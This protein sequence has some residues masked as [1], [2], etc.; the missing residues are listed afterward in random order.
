MNK[1]KKF[2]CIVASMMTCLL[3]FPMPIHAQE[4]IVIKSVDDFSDFAKKA[5]LDTWSKDKKIILENDLDFSNTDFISIPYFAGTFD[6][7]G[8]TLSGIRLLAS[9]PNQ[10][11]FR[12]LDEAGTIQ[13]LKVDVTIIGK[14]DIH[15]IG[16]IVGENRG[17]ILDCFAQVEM[18]GDAILGGIAGIN[19]TS[20][21]IIHC[22]TQGIITSLQY[23]G[24]IVGKNYGTISDCTNQSKI[25]PSSQE[26]TINL[27]EID[28]NHITNLTED[29]HP[30]SGHSDTGGIA[31]YS[32]GII[33][34]CLN[35]ANLG[36]PHIGYN[37]GGIV[38]RQAGYLSN[39]KNTGTIYGRKDVGGIVGQMEPSMVLAY[40][41]DSLVKLRNDLNQL[42]A[43]ID[44]ALDHNDVNIADLSQQIEGLANAT[45]EAKD[46]SNQ[47]IQSSLDFMDESIGE[48]NRTSA[49]IVDLIQDASKIAKDL[50]NA[51]KRSDD[52]LKS[53]DHVLKKGSDFTHENEQLIRVLKKL[54]LE[55]SLSKEKMEQGLKEI[56]EALELLSRKASVEEEIT[57]SDLSQLSQ[58][59]KDYAKGFEQANQS[60]GMLRDLEIENEALNQALDQVLTE[61]Q[62]LNEEMN[63]VADEL[64]QLPSGQGLE[65]FAEAM[66]KL[67]EGFQALSESSF[68]FQ[69]AMIQLE[70][71]FDELKDI[72]EKV[73]EIFKAFRLVIHEVEKQSDDIVLAMKKTTKLLE[74]AGDFDPFTLPQVDESFRQNTDSL[75]QSLTDMGNQLKGINQQISHS[76]QVLNNDLRAISHQFNSIMQ[77]LIQ[78]LTENDE[79]AQLEDTSNEDLYASMEGKVKGSINLGAV[80]GDVNVGGITGSMAIEVSLDPEDDL[81]SQNERSLHFRLETKAVMLEC[82]NKGKVLAK[83]DNVGGLVGR[84]DLGTVSDCESYGDVESS[85][86]KYVGGIAGSSV[87]TIQNCYAKLNLKGSSYV[88]GI[89]G[90]GHE[91]KNCYSLVE[92]EDAKGLVGAVL[93]HGDNLETIWNNYFVDQGIAGIDG[94]SYAQKAEPKSMD[95]LK[96]ME[97]PQN[98]MTF[99]LTYWVDGKQVDQIDFEY[100]EDLSAYLLPSIPSKEGYYGQWPEF[101]YT[102]V[103]FSQ[104]FEAEYLPWIRVISSELKEKNQAVALAEGNFTEKAQLKAEIVQGHELPKNVTADEAQCIQ[105]N[106]NDEAMKESDIHAIR[107]LKKG[108]SCH[109]YQWVD[110]AWQVLTSKEN[111]SY[112]QVELQ[113]NEALYCVVAVQNSL[114]WILGGGLLAFVII[115]GFI[116]V[117]KH[118][119]KK[120]ES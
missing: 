2:C 86:G 94:I 15:G 33:Q 83:K 6:G 117:K 82:V 74:K 85:N 31:G 96:E 114:Y 41:N 116:I 44:S 67:K 16:G 64:L 68:L 14:S 84:M 58:G 38:G 91:L 24:G 87:S 100:G 61:G 28:V 93:G 104:N 36:Y 27:E 32:S 39:C 99:S 76:S 22:S 59:M 37:V 55:L 51:A 40:S 92:I 23:S 107:L 60:M 108:S 80:E 21:Q 1:F 120:L 73:N 62:E 56:Q 48:V 53:L 50:E 29:T 4:E 115:C 10:G 30:I 89:A 90:E 101:D 66:D 106:L 8:H 18:D 19:Q 13:N 109:V 72:N 26:A 35:Q 112:V 110:G 77:N 78:A 98:F 105:V 54:T 3:A 71:A 34:N 42:Q 118:S 95:E 88:G 47:L 102:E 97:L 9:T 113:G 46:Y 43:L 69:K 65:N 79:I 52:V 119:K 17:K 25:N 11:V 63:E 70:K 45:L 5:Q 81:T 12:Y 7:Q 75:N 111:G 49:Q 57:F 20:G 103:K